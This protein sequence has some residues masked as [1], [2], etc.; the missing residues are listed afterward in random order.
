MSRLHLLG[1][2]SD[3]IADLLDEMGEPRFRS[4]QICDWVFGKRVESWDAMRNIPKA[5]RDKLAQRCILRCMEASQTQKS[6]NGLTDKWLFRTHDGHGVEAVLIRDQ[7][8]R[9][10]CI[11]CSIG[12]GMS[13]TFCAS[14]MGRF[15]RHL[16]CGEMLEQAAHIEAFTGERISNIV[17]MGT[18]E[19]FSNYDEVLA[20]ARQFNHPDVFGIGARHIT[21][22]TVGVITGI[23]RFAAEPEDFRL[24]ISLHAPSQAIRETIIP[25]AKKWHFQRILDMVRQYNRATRREVTIEYTLI[26]DVNSEPAHASL[27]AKALEGIICKVNCIPLNPVPGKPYLPPSDRAC[28][29]FAGILESRGLRTTLRME[30]GQD[31]AAACG[32][33]RA[34][35]RLRPA[36]DAKSTDEVT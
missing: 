32:Q 25:S 17:F 28:H 21:I 29:E 20:A 31:I 34:I 14:G 6:A 26:K 23:D 22:S 11:S 13:C 9:T 18:G 36:D 15:I 7:D 19:P 33:L 3:A 24:A 1:T 5:L 27:L 10:V 8:R 16:S 35:T 30:K 2:T 12:C 4:K